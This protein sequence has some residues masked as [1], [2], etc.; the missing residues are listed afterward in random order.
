MRTC[1]L[2]HFYSSSTSTLHQKFINTGGF[3]SLGGPRIF[4]SHLIIVGHP[5]QGFYQIC[6]SL[7]NHFLLIKEKQ[8]V[9][10]EKSATYNLLNGCIA[11]IYPYGNVNR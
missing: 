8:T 4:E 5:I 9:Y 11:I 1:I 6:C 10:T 7:Q 2:E 3:R